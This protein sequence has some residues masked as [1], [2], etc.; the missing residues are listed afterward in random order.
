[1]K[2]LEALEKYFV[3]IVL[4]VKKPTVLLPAIGLSLT[5]KNDFLMIY[6]LLILFASDFVTGVLASYVVFKKSN[7]KGKFFSDKEDGFTSARWR[8]TFVKAITYFL[9]IILTKIIEDAFKIKVFEFSFTDHKVT[10]SMISIAFSCACEFYSI[11]WE[12]LPKAGFS[13]WDMFK[14]ITGIAK[15]AVSDIKSISNDSNSAS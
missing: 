11:F 4:A 2:E 13:I 6:L 9:L 7:K 12:N 14:K 10:I 8:L 3:N 5:F 1:M 15:E